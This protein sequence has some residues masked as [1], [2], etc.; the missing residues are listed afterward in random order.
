LRQRL[1]TLVHDGGKE[2]L[3]PQR[4]RAAGP[5]GRESVSGWVAKL[6]H[7][8]HQNVFVIHLYVSSS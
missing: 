7:R 4:A 2:A 5:V 3:K 8:R 6:P 1:R